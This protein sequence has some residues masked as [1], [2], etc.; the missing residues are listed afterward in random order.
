MLP[1]VNVVIAAY[2]HG[3]NERNCALSNNSRHHDSTPPPPPPPNAPPSRIHI[4]RRMSTYCYWMSRHHCHGARRGTRPS[5][6]A[7][8]NNKRHLNCKKYTH[9]HTH[10]TRDRYATGDRHH[11]HSISSHSATNQMCSLERQRHAATSASPMTATRPPIYKSG[12]CRMSG[13]HCH[14]ARREARPST[15]PSRT[16]SDTTAASTLPYHI[17]RIKSRSMKT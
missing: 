5:N 7:L 1:G 16:T 6:C 10:S 12:S 14:S 3:I 2:R 9:T 4:S 15:A 13:R 8:S 11:C 17:S